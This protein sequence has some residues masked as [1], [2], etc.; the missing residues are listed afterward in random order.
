MPTG[1]HPPLADKHSNPQGRMFQVLPAG[2]AGQAPFLPIRSRLINPENASAAS[3]FIMA[4]PLLQE[5][6]DETHDPDARYQ[7][8]DAILPFPA[9]EATHKPEPARERG[10]EEPGAFET[11]LA[12]HDERPEPE[13]PA[14]AEQKQRTDLS[15]RPGEETHSAKEGETPTSENP[16]TGEAQQKPVSDSEEV[17]EGGPAETATA[18][19]TTSKSNEAVTSPLT[20]VGTTPAHQETAGGSEAAQS[21]KPTDAENPS[22][23]NSAAV[24]LTNANSANGASNEATTGEAPETAAGHASDTVPGRPEQTAKPDNNPSADELTAVPLPQSGAEDADLPAPLAGALPGNTPRT[25]G[26]AARNQNTAGTATA[27][28]V[29]PAANAGPS[30]V[31]PTQGAGG[32]PVT[33]NSP[34]FSPSAGAEHA[35]TGPA[36]AKPTSAGLPPNTPGAAPLSEAQA[37]AALPKEIAAAHADAVGAARNAGASTLPLRAEAQAPARTPQDIAVRIARGAQAGQSRFEIR[38]DPPELGRIDIRLE[39]NADG[40]MQAVL[41]A[42]KPET[43]DMLQRDA[44]ALERALADQGMDMSGGGLN[45]ALRQ[46]TPDKDGGAGY[47]SASNT[48][49]GTEEDALGAEL[50]ALEAGG[51]L[52]ERRLGVDM[53]I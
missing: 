10:R 31:Q 17:K 19:T 16:D 8:P 2:D 29:N 38:L 5:S 47:G 32:S 43:L 48:G 12:A 24:S 42:D 45:F 4:P 14:R 36:L 37:A 3:F 27:Q 20:A 1:P 53:R 25:P 23:G 39:M 50:S 40:R 49:S 6:A 44:R 9:L 30:S 52:V 11:E 18:A 26:E 22:P 28:N 33:S 35:E 13:A 7:M 15:G 51:L 46:E 41:Q 34:G 21:A